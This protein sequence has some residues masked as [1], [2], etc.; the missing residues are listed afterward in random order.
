MLRRIL[1]SIALSIFLYLPALANSPTRIIVPFA[2][3]GMSDITA[4]ILAEGISLETG[5]PVTVENRPGGF[6]IVGLEHLMRQPADGRTL[7]IAANG[8]TT[9]KYYLP[10]TSVDPITRLSIVSVAV[11]ASMLMLVSNNVPNASANN[12]INYALQNPNLLNYATVGQGGTAQMSADLLFRNSGIRLTPVP[13]PGIAPATIDLAAGRIH[14]IFDTVA[15]GMQAVRAGNAIPLA[16]TSSVRSRGAPDIP[17]FRELGYDIEF[18]AWQAVFVSAATPQ[19]IK[20]RTNQIIRRALQNPATIRRY[21]E[22]GVDKIVNSTLQESENTLRDEQRR[23]D[24][25]LGNR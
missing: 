6:T 18:N 10:N 13:Y 8:V 11:E 20:E 12:F 16:V 22:L 3:G 5:Q 14:L 2:P 21:N 24:R 23:W 25:I 17:T 7:F 19:P 9:H 1:A 4:R 15:V